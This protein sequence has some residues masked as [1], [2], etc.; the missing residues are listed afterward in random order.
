MENLKFTYLFNYDLHNIQN[1]ES[2][3]E[4]NY[5]EGKDY[6]KTVGRGDD[7]MNALSLMSENCQNDDELFDLI[8]LCDLLR[9]V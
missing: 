1:V 6:V 5:I 7:V 3:L 4:E 9:I 2:Y 8:H